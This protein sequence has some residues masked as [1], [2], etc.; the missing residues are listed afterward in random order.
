M[1]SYEISCSKERSNRIMADVNVPIPRP[2][3]E[4]G[5]PIIVKPSSQSG[6][7]GVSVANNEQ[8]R[9]R[10]LRT[11]EKLEDVPI[12][13]E[14]VSGKSVSIEVIGNGSTSRSYI[15]TEVVLDSNYDCKQ[16]ICEPD[17]LPEADNDLFGKI[18]RDIADNLGLKAL[19]DVEAIYT[20]KGLRVLEI[21]AR[22]P[23]QTPAA[24]EAATGINLLEELVYS[25][26]GKETGKK[27]KGDCS[28]YEHYL[29]RD[30]LLITCG[31]KEFGHIDKPYFDSGLFGSDD[32][33]TDYMPDKTEWRATVIN[34]GRTSADV[35][36]K[37]KK[38]INSV[39]D[40]C[41]LDEYVDRVPEM[42]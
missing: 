14:F 26:L 22:I 17:I 13:Q 10:G 12:Q 6:S 16:V 38:F 4:C 2:W 21:D 35:L 15:T 24:I 29:I 41:E 20:K 3:P 40:R 25:A 9:L 7:I 28:V 27:S 32:I 5:F 1:A 19:M 8:E 33:I 39:M 34:H 23:S 42:I 18:G 36:E 37:R 11:V 31:E 30:G